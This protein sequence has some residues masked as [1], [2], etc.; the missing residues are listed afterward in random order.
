M[1]VSTLRSGGDT[2]VKHEELQLRKMI[3]QKTKDA[4]LI[5]VMLM[6]LTKQLM[7]MQRGTDWIFMWLGSV[8]KIHPVQHDQTE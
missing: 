7:H 1:T 3:C 4:L 5:W 6:S 8:E 2:L